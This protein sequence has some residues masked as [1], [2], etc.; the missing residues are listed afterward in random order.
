MDTTF[1]SSVIRTDVWANEIKDI[2]QEELIGD[3]LVRWISEFPK[4]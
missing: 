3:R 1:N 2:L 4:Q